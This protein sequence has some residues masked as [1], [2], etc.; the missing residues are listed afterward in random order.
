MEIRESL[1]KR[2]NYLIL[3]VFLFA[4]PPMLKYVDLIY[5]TDVM[6]RVFVFGLFA[7]S[8]DILVGCTGL[9]N[10]GHFAFFGLG[11]Y[12]TVYILSPLGWTLNNFAAAAVIAMIVCMGAALLFAMLVKRAFYGIPFTFMSLAFGMIVYMLWRNTLPAKWSG[13]DTGF[14]YYSLPGVIQSATTTEFFEIG[15]FIVIAIAVLL[16]VY[17]KIKNSD[18]GSR[19]KKVASVIGIILG[20]FLIFIA[21]GH[22][23]ETVSGLPQIWTGYLVEI[24]SASTTAS[25]VNTTN[26]YYI[27]LVILVLSYLISSRFVHSPVGRVWQAIR[28][29]ETRVEVLGYSLFKYK[30][31]AL[32]FAAALGGLSGA[33]F[34][35]YLPTVPY[36]TVFNPMVAFE[37]IIYIIVGG[38]GTLAGGPVGA[39]VTI[40]SEEIL[41]EVLPFEASAQIALVI[42]GIV[43]I[44]VVFS[45]PRGIVGTWRY[46][47]EGK[48]VKEKIKEFVSI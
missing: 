19:V 45:I 9:L 20:V 36:S 24:W 39:G 22:L 47:R 43:F 28:E 10:F 7:L 15:I 2:S 3:L 42:I 18:I 5:Y 6:V 38:V 35:L 46:G 41:K 37:A 31:L 40:L 33:L 13:G 30:T 34:T 14:S 27:T 4:L 29:D 48:S 21:Y 17:W 32:M 25:V 16:G 1:Q 26:T 44:I 8:F 11:A 23:A 12:F